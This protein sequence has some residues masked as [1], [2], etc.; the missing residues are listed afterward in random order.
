M[1]LSMTYIGDACV[2]MK[3]VYVHGG[4]DMLLLMETDD[5]GVVMILVCPQCSRDILSMMNIDEYHTG[6]ANVKVSNIVGV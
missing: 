6:N 5:D 1:V 2:L 3:V 4:Q